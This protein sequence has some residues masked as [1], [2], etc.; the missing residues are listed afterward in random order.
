[1]ERSGRSDSVSAFVGAR[2]APQV[3]DKAPD[4]FVETPDGRL[5]LSQLAARRG[6]VILISRDSYQFHPG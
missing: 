1:M 3:G 6:R 2:G 5:L 4:F